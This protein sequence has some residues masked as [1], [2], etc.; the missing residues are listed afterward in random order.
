M[1]VH[2]LQEDLNRG[3]STV[4]KVITG[5][6][7]L[8]VLGNVLLIADK[9]G[10]TIVATNLELGMRVEVGGK[11]D[12]EGTVTVP[13][14]NLTEF[15]GTIPSGEVILEAEK[16]K[17]SVK[18]G[19]FV[20]TFATIP[21]AEFPHVASLGEA[22]KGQAPRTKLSKTIVL[23]I[24]RE[25]AFA[26][27]MDESRPVLTGVQFRMYNEQFIITATDG[28][29]M[30][31][32]VLSTQYLG[33]KDG[34]ILPAKTIMEL[35]RMVGES[36]Q[37]EVEMQAVAENNQMIFGHGKVQLVSRVLEGSFPDVD[38]IVPKEFATKV[39]IDREEL[40]KATRAIAIFARE[41]ANVVKFIMHNGQGT[42]KAVGG[43][44][45]EGTVDIDIELEGDDVEV[46]FNFRY[47]LDYLQAVE[48][49]RVILSTSGSLTPGVWRVEGREDLT[50]LIMPVRV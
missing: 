19:K 10:L 47:L 14:R 25:V 5:R 13:A 43:Q 46:A 41:S 7:Q 15:V 49:E 36:K 44:I 28:F 37:E 39:T 33:L 34:L 38:K 3:L 40:L 6:G 30:S 26:A 17:I 45:G 9:A 21:A 22:M 50:H 1:K 12:Q 16:E 18:S 35:A 27:A 23:E 32:K 42:I 24:A 4:G 8:P 2:I 48:G 29:R 11:V 31:R 20:G